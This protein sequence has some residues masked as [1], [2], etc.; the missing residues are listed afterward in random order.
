MS[1]ENGTHVRTED[2]IR[3]LKGHSVV[4]H[5]RHVRAGEAKSSRC[6]MCRS[7]STA[8]VATV[9]KAAPVEERSLGSSDGADEEG[10]GAS[11]YSHWLS[12]GGE[13][14]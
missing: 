3:I 4:Y 6:G 1:K 5:Y 14:V 7:G 8:F 2:G 9:K 12:G 10:V 11:P 13:P